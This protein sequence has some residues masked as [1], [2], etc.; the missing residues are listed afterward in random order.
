MV[1]AQIKQSL[2]GDQQQGPPS[3]V[4]PQYTQ[5]TQYAQNIPQPPG[6]GRAPSYQ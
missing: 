6:Y 3:Y 5:Y 2:M 1:D 4:T